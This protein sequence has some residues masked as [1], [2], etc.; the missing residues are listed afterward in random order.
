M[1][2]PL[3]K[4]SLVIKSPVVNGLLVK[5]GSSGG[6]TGKPSD[7]SDIRKDCPANSIALYAGHK[8]DYSQY[9]NLGFTATCTGG[10]NVFIDGT[11]YGTTYASGAQC[12]I[13]WS[14]SGITTG[15]DITTP[16]ALKA[17]KIWIEPATEGAEI[18]AFKFQRVADSGSE[19]QGCLWTHFNIQNQIEL[20]MFGNYVDIMGVG[21]RNALLTAITAKK[22]KLS[23]SSLYYAFINLTNLEYIPEFVYASNF[24]VLLEGAFDRTAIKSLTIKN[25]AISSLVTTCRYC[26]ELETVNIDNVDL[27]GLEHAS[28]FIVNSTKL[29]DTVFDFSSSS[30]LKE[31]GIYGDNSNFISGM[32]GLRVSSSAPF[33]NSTAPQINISYTG[34]TRQALVTLFNDLPTVSD[35]QII[36]ITGCTGSQQLSDD[37]IAIA[38]SKGWTVTGG[39]A[40]QVYATYN[41]SVGDTIK[42]NDGMATSEYT[43]SAYPSDTAI[44]GDYTQTATVTA[45]D[46]NN[47]IECQKP[48]QDNKTATVTTDKHYYAFTNY[49]DSSD[50]LYSLDNPPISSGSSF[51]QP[52]LSS[53]GTLGGNSFAVSLTNPYSATYDAWKAFDNNSGTC[54]WTQTI[55]AD[56]IIYNPEPLKVTALHWVVYD[57]NRRPTDWEWYGSNDNITYTLLNSGTNTSNDFTLDLTGDAYKY[58]KFKIVTAFNALNAKQIDLTAE[59]YEQSVLF[60]KVSDNFVELNPQPEFTVGTNS[61]TVTSETPN[62]TYN[63]NSDNDEIKQFTSNIE[64]IDNTTIQTVTITSDQDADIVTSTNVTTDNNGVVIANGSRHNFNIT[65]PSSLV[66][67]MQS[68]GQQYN[69]AYCPYTLKTNTGVGLL[70][71]NGNDVYYRNSWVMTRDYDLHYQQINFSYPS[72]ATVTCRVNNVLQNDLT[73]YCYAGDTIT[74]SCYN[75]GTVTTGSYTVKY[76]SK[77]GNIQTI[78]IS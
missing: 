13:T 45:V 58:H 3:I 49:N 57:Y 52:T 42:L 8:E 30:L 51:T 62:I 37:E 44:T 27:S 33:D 59:V 34:M 36:N 55:P 16:S 19:E 7:W 67:I 11:Q 39:P 61:I 5:G 50:T 21:Y 56:L 69:V 64:V 23:V 17:H 26:S 12:S 10:Y 25:T 63:R 48:T 66:S 77:D 40:Y 47:I 65:V 14:T 72:G 74:W 29:K 1:I 15:D 53:N 54:F 73:P 24:N 75:A 78:T 41:A 2:T 76:S 6:W 28:Q 46:G 9:D 70:L 20:T 31:I 38:E 22:N 68:G 4:K 60:E 43:W 35:G 32:K 18:T 71:K